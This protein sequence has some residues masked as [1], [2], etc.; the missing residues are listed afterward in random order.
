MEYNFKVICYKL[1]LLISNR[2]WQLSAE[3]KI[4]NET[5]PKSLYLNIHFFPQAN[6]YDANLFCRYHGMQLATINSPEAQE[7]INQVI[8]ANG[9]RGIVISTRKFSFKL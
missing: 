9:P 1:L 5:F 3:L 4:L 8:E 2:F 6:W 7:N